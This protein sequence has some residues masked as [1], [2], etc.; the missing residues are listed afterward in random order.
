MYDD[1]LEV[2]GI[3]KKYA[4]FLLSDVTFCVPGGSIV[5]V[6]GEN[7]AGK[8]TT[9]KTILNI[10]SADE[11]TVKFCG[12]QVCDLSAF[13]KEEIGVVF[14]DS[15]F[16]E[17]LTAL[18]LAKIFSKIYTRWDSKYYFELMGRFNLSKDKKLSE[19]SKGMKSKLAL[20]CALSHYPKLLVIDESLSALDPVIRDEVLNLLHEFV[21]DGKKAV[22]FSC[23][24]VEDLQKIADYI[25]FINHGRVI[26]E[27]SI[28]ELLSENAIIQCDRNQMEKIDTG[29]VIAY[30]REGSSI[31]VMLHNTVRVKEKYS[32]FCVKQATIDEIMRIMI[33]GEWA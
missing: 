15:V 23:H 20:I 11:G 26:F 18:E 16:Y 5:G 32:N 31:A 13:E 6:V 24:I 12:K 3:S 25:V 27:K 9:L 30:C 17:N 29:D 28:N 4:D 7:G 14:D 33:K 19:Y 21:A 2:N 22:L 8:S 10:C 1:V